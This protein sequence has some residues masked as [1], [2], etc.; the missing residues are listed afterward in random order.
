M[1]QPAPAAAVAAATT[2]PALP[3]RTPP[4][5][6]DDHRAVITR[7]GVR[8]LMTSLCLYAFEMSD[9]AEAEGFSG[10]GWYDLAAEL[11][12]ITP[13][14]EESLWGE[15]RHFEAPCRGCRTGGE[16]CTC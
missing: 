4:V 11:D 10:N 2:A 9:A 8:A 1:D 5:L 6:S 7:I 3:R 14:S 12:E 16:R 15:E 13:I